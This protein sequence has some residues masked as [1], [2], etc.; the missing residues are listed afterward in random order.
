MDS[1]NTEASLCLGHGAA[2][3]SVAMMAFCSSHG[4][5]HPLATLDGHS[6]CRVA[7]IFISE[8][9]ARKIILEEISI[10]RLPS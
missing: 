9:F 3:A 8:N 2:K 4:L 5:L 10:E 1:I 7:F 6:S